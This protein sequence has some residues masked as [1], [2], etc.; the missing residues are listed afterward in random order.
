MIKVIFLLAYDYEYVKYSLPCVY[1]HADQI[2]FSLDKNRISWSG[3]SFKFDDSIL[4]WIK[5]YDKDH[6][7]QIYEDNFY[8]PTNSPMQNDTRQRQM[9]ANFLGKGG[10]TLMI[11][12]DE[13]FLNFK[14]F[15]KLLQVYEDYL[16]NPSKTPIS[17][18]ANWINVFKQD[19]AGFYYISE[20]N[21]PVKIATNL[22]EYTMARD[23]NHYTYYSDFVIVHQSWARPKEEMK[24][25]L[26][27][28]SH[29][30]D[31]INASNYYEFWLGV[32]E[33]NY[34]SVKNFC[35]AYP[36]SAWKRLDL[37]KAKDPNELIEMSK[38]F[39]PNKFFLYRKNI[40]QQLRKNPFFR[41]IRDII[42]DIL[43]K[44]SYKG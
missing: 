30:N 41:N 3:N 17:I 33:S 1:D 14:D 9:S 24:F 31:V 29:K 10:W 12:V 44:R 37:I 21:F 13:Y 6:K 8:E 36:P 38:D 11:D 27:N 20:S 25:K 16:I 15:V 42:V 43:R 40:I 22:P 5:S 26:E 28:W 4:E 18:A 34:K 7:I 2:L 32:N 19:D 23:L 39:R 35:N